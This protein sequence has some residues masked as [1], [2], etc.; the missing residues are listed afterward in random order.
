[1]R[2]RLIALAALALAA[3]VH[4]HDLSDR[5]GAFLGALLHP[6][7]ALDHAAA[8]F[9]LGLLAGLQLTM[10]GRMVIGFALAL[11]TSVVAAATWSLAPPHLTAINI[12]S[13]PVLGGLV[14]LARPLP[15]SLAIAVALF[16]GVTHGWENGGDIAADSNGWLSALGVVSAGLLLTVPA[17]GLARALS[18]G[19]PRVAVRVGG[20]W[21]AALGLMMLG[22]HLR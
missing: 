15:S 10:T 13:L 2:R 14:A 22:L 21:I 8:F 7:F 1:M 17:A 19:W 12:A 20:S 9:A 16:F 18:R 11:F 3:P 4:A 5:Y 6:L